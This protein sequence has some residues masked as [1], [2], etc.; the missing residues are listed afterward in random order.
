TRA[1]YV[2]GT[3]EK[4]GGTVVTMGTQTWDPIAKTVTVDVT[5]SN[6]VVGQTATGWYGFTLEVQDAAGV[7]SDSVHAGVYTTCLEAA[8]ADPADNTIE[9]NWPN[10]HGDING[11]CVTNLEDLALLAL[12]WVD[13]M[14]VKAG[15]TP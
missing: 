8:L 12:S 10:G 1:E 6:P 4:A 2:E 7:G 14:T 13:C 3:H 15:C 9:T 11:D 5:V